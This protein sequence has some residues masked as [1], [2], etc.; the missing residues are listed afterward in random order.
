MGDTALE[1]G[2]VGEQSVQMHRVGVPGDAGEH[3]DVGV[4]DRL[5]VDGGHAGLQVL[6]VVAVLLFHLGLLPPAIL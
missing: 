1:G 5:G 4:G 3:D 2:L 6:E